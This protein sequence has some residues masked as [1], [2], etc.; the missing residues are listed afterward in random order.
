MKNFTSTVSR[1]LALVRKVL[2]GKRLQKLNESL[3]VLDESVAQGSWIMRGRV[4]AESGFYQG[5]TRYVRIDGDGDGRI[6]F[7][8]SGAESERL[9]RLTMCLNYGQRFTGDLSKALKS[10]RK[11][12]TEKNVYKPTDAQIQGWVELVAAARATFQELDE[13]RPKPVIT[14]IG[15]SP[16]VTKT[17]KEMNLDIDISTIKEPEI[18]FYWWKKLDPKTMKPMLDPRGKFIREKRFYVKWEKGTQHNMSR[19]ALKGDHCEACSKVIKHFVPLEAKDNRSGKWVSL[20]VGMD[21]AKNI[22]GVK[23]LGFIGKLKS[24]RG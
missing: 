3:K 18:K 22:F 14:K 23:T 19:F 24:K 2:S 21:C 13:A 11:H 4:K 8:I 20:W 16:K 6:R 15:L 10:F 17:L 9:H 12:T 1:Q 5:F 7:D